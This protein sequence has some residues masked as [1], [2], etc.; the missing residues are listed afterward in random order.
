MSFLFILNYIDLTLFQVLRE[1]DEISETF[2]CLKDIR[3]A[4]KT[5]KKLLGPALHFPP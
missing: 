4:V 2:K 1:S 5:D 3:L